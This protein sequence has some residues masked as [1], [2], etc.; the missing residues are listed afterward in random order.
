[1][2]RR[3][4]LPERKPDFV[5]IGAQKSAS[6]F[7]AH[8][9]NQHPDIYIPPRETHYFRNPDYLREPP[10]TLLNLFADNGS[11]RRLGIK[12]ADYLA[13]PECPA[14]LRRDLDDPQLLVAL[15]HPVD[16]AVSAYFWYLR[17]N[18]LPFA[19]LEVGLPKILS[20]EYSG[21]IY[22]RAREVLD[23]GLYAKHLSR[24]LEHFSRD[25]L[26]VALDC[27]LNH[28]S[29]DVVRSALEFIGVDPALGPH[30]VAERRNAGVYSLARLDVIRRRNR[31]LVPQESARTAMTIRLPHQPVPLL[32]AA[33]LE[34]LDRC[35]LARRDEHHPPTLPTKL[36]QHLEAFYAEDIAAL[37]SL[38]GR[39]LSSWS[40]AV[41]VT[42][43]AAR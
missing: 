9:L 26:F 7:L 34:L 17:W 37:G 22:P 35:V 13:R 21:T 32:K 39:D 5:I 8:A 27:E 20:G 18:C 2:R 33:T 4:R 12:S 38:L 40:P 1:M 11:A 16:R 25:R 30:D 14:R 43:S 10:A 15:R 31:H 28:D 23:W 29:R 42:A 41:G 6:T 19:P 3:Q 36:K 24:Y